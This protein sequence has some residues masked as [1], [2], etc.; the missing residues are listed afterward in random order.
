MSNKRSDRVNEKKEDST[1]MAQ[2][3]YRDDNG[4]IQKHATVGW[5][6][7]ILLVWYVAGGTMMRRQL[8]NVS[9]ERADRLAVRFAM[10]TKVLILFRRRLN[11]SSRTN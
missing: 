11:C 1:E 3:R 10:K 8:A 7:I 9:A 6:I 5:S 2:H 4:T